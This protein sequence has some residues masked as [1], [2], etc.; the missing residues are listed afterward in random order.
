MLKAVGDRQMFPMQTKSTLSFSM[1]EMVPEGRDNLQG[2]FYI[3]CQIAPILVS[4][5]DD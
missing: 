1:N 5:V 3:F 4:L 2:A